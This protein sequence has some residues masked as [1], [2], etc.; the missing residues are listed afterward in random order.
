MNLAINN[1]R[2][3]RGGRKG[4]DMPYTY[5]KDDEI[6]IRLDLSRP[7]IS[8]SYRLIGESD[9]PWIST[10]FQRSDVRDENEA[11]DIVSAWLDNQGTN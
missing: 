2:Y 11:L 10:S 4:N 1:N 3:H 6:E 8:I 7:E 5:A 9:G